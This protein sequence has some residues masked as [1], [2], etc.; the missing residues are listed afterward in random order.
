MKNIMDTNKN[1]GKL[2][3]K[4][5]NKKFL[6]GKVLQNYCGSEDKSLIKLL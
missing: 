6:A 4:F 3:E 5:K 1:R 2:S